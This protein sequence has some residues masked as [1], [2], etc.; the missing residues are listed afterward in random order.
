MARYSR[1]RWTAVPTIVDAEASWLSTTTTWRYL[2]A[3]TVSYTAAAG[4]PATWI[5][6]QASA[7]ARARLGLLVGMNVLN[8]GTSASGI[9]GS[10]PGKYAMSATQL[11]NWGSAL[12]AEDRACGLVLQRYDSRYFGRSDVAGA[13]AELGR[14]AG[15]VQAS[16]CRVR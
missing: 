11:R 1:A 12:L 6:R 16:S 13:I 8:G 2:D 3:A 7:A 14:K 15:E 9:A 5:S 4:D 10:Q